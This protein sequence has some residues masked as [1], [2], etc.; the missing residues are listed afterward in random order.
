MPIETVRA[1]FI[2]PMLLLAT[3]SLPEA[4]GW[5]YELKLD[6]YRALPSKPADASSFGRETTKISTANI[7]PSLLVLQ[8]SQTK[9]SSMER[10]WPWM[11]RSAFVQFAAE[12]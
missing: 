8:H 2:E 7:H 4:E 11:T 6:G 9:Q 12:L 5:A 3:T 1:S 10:L